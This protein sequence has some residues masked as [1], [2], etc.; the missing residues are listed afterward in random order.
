[1]TAKSRVVKPLKLTPIETW[2]RDLRRQFINDGTHIAPTFTAD[3][4]NG[5]WGIY[6]EYLWEDPR[7]NETRTG[8]WFITYSGV[9]DEAGVRE[10][11]AR[12]DAL[13]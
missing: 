1:M 8:H 10:V 6:A 7:N 2:V 5:R 13:T 4:Q 11:A 12:M 9:S 3:R